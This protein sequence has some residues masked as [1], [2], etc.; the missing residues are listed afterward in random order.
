MAEGST[1]TKELTLKESVIIEILKNSRSNVEKMFF[2]K[3][4]DGAHS[5]ADMERTLQE[6]AKHLAK[7][8]THDFRPGR[9]SNGVSEVVNAMDK[10]V[11]LAMQG[12][13]LGQRCRKGSD[14][15]TADTVEAE[16]DGDLNIESAEIQEEDLEID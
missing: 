6:L 7:E 2:I 1:R 4:P 9:A 8:G 15:A 5:P 11:H 12:P 10:G 16:E 14:D 3:H 13:Q